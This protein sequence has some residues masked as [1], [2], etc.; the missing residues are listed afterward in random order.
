MPKGGSRRGGG[1]QGVRD[2]PFCGRNFFFFNTKEEKKNSEW[3]IKKIKDVD[4]TNDSF[5]GKISTIQCTCK[6]L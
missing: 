5:T 2:P 1:V 6:F 3:K 4:K